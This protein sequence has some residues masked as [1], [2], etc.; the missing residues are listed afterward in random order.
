MGRGKVCVLAI[1]RS[2]I[3]HVVSEKPG[4]TS[5]RGV[6]LKAVVGTRYAEVVRYYPNSPT[7]CLGVPIRNYLPVLRLLNR[8]SGVWDDVQLGMYTKGPPRRLLG[9]GR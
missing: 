6:F 8:D 9:P 5:L 7:I 2:E 3:W 1:N 4:D